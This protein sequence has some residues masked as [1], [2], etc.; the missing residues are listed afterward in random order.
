MTN[1]H[2]YTR[3]CSLTE[4]QIDANIKSSNVVLGLFSIF[5][6]SCQLLAEKNANK[7][8]NNMNEQRVLLS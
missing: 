1:N 3:T 8:L 5:R 7:Y 2:L 6:E 4:I